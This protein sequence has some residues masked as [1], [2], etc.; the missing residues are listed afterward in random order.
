MPRKGY[1]PRISSSF[2]VN[3]YGTPLDVLFELSGTPDEAKILGAEWLA[4]FA[5]KGHDVIAYLRREILLHSSQSQMTYPT[6]SY[7][8]SHSHALRELQYTFDETQSC[9]WW[10][11]WTDP[12]SQIDLLEREFTQI[13]KYTCIVPLFVPLSW[14]SSWPFQYPVWHDFIE[15]DVEFWPDRS[16]DEIDHGLRQRGRYAMRRAERRLKKRNAKSTYS[17]SFRYP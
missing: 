13:I 8:N 9:V 14:M 4:L 3:F 5:A 1:V 7:H 10:D 2:H 17:K 12:A 15:E 6:A 16:E 11:W